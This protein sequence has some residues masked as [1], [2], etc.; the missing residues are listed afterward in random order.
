MEIP[1]TLRVGLFAFSHSNQIRLRGIVSLL[2][3]FFIGIEKLK[4]NLKVHQ[5]TE[6]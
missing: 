1:L 4:L 6:S 5:K 2:H 3:S